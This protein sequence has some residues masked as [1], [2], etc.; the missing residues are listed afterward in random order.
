MQTCTAICFGLSGGQMVNYKSNGHYNIATCHYQIS[1]TIIM[2]H[3]ELSFNDR[4]YGTGWR[5]PLI[6]SPRHGNLGLSQ[7]L[8]DLFIR[9]IVQLLQ[10]HPTCLVGEAYFR[11]NVDRS[12]LVLYIHTLSADL[13]LPHFL[14]P[15]IRPEGCYMPL[16]GL[17]WS[18]PWNVQLWLLWGSLSPTR[19]PL[20]TP[21]D[22]LHGHVITASG[23]DDSWGT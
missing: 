14:F 6:Q 23:L 7:I 2:K 20:G 17:I 13:S 22:F 8:L 9:K 19:A 11:G 10:D 12:K 4:I 5:Y 16:H 21:R 15:C 18:G 1:C 3:T